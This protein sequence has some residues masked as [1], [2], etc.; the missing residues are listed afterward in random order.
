MTPDE[1]RAAVLRAIHRVAPEVDPAAIEPD[2][3]LREQLDIDS[4]DFLKFVITL[5]ESLGVDVP[6]KDY[7]RLRT[8]DSCVG[9]LMAVGGQTSNASGAD[10]RTASPSGT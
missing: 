8:V 7:S 5:H 1:T 10:S 2:V 9:Y 6:E 3:P 4:M